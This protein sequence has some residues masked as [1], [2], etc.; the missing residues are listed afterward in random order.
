MTLAVK[1][2]VQLQG[3]APVMLIAASVYDYARQLLGAGNGTITGGTEPADPPRAAIDPHPIGLALDLRTG[4]LDLDQVETLFDI[5]KQVNTLF[6]RGAFLFILESDHIH[7]Q[8]VN[9]R[10]YAPTAV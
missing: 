3:V 5:L 9:W 4:D 2:G 10:K 6:L 7:V 8:L 1:A